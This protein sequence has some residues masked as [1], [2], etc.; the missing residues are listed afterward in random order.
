VE[1][2]PGEKAKELARFISLKSERYRIWDCVK[3]SLEILSTSAPMSQRGLVREM[4]VDV[5]NAKW[6]HSGDYYFIRTEWSAVDRAHEL[7]LVEEVGVTPHGV[8]AFR[9]TD[10]GWEVV[11]VLTEG[12]MNHA[13]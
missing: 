12:G 1:R 13:G 3:Q 6:V 5:V 2:T 10:L 4:G 8:T 11:T 9:L 7:G